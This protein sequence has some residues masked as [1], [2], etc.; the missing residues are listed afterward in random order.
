MTS[1]VWHRE[2]I[3]HREN[4]WKL[5]HLCDV[6]L[7]KLSKYSKPFYLNIR[8][9]LPGLINIKRRE[10]ELNIILPTKN[11]FDITQKKTCFV[12]IHI[13]NTEQELGR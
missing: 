3:S 10:A 2:N 4:N 9:Y 1:E 7:V 12:L 5:F 6:Y 13:A 11:N 8:N